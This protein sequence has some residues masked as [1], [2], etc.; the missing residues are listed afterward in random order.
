[1]KTVQERFNE[2]YKV[3]QETGCWEWTA[4]KH[5]RGY[6]Q[7]AIASGKPI[8][9]HRASYLLHVGEIPHGMC[10]CHRCDNRQCVNPSHLF[11]GTQADNVMDMMVKGRQAD[12][13]G[14]KGGHTLSE[15]DVR[16]I[17][18]MSN[19]FPLTKRQSD[20][21]YGVGGFL[22]RWFGVHRVQIQSVIKGRTWKHVEVTP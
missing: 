21:S 17:R 7:F 16:L 5:P 22:S 12:L 2:K 18:L 13:R 8:G 15:S 11:L 14:E 4:S 9:A 6:G 3:N 19:R 20:F 10:V 1:M